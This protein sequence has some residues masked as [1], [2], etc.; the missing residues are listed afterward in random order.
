LCFVPNSWEK[1][2]RKLGMENENWVSQ[3]IYIQMI[4]ESKV[5]LLNRRNKIIFFCH[6][7]IILR[8]SKNILFSMHLFTFSSMFSSV[9]SSIFSLFLRS[10]YRLLSSSTFFKSPSF[11]FS[12]FSTFSNKRITWVIKSRIVATNKK[13]SCRSS[14]SDK[15]SKYFLFF[16]TQKPSIKFGILI[17]SSI[18]KTKL[19]RFTTI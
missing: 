13:K 15:N 8:K 18:W 4:R 19:S 14:L 1:D 10:S 12:K 16:F 3:E 9:F 6:F 17:L 2:Q 5:S 7:F 11:V